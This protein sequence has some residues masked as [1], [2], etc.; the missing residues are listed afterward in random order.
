[1]IKAFS[2]GRDIYATIA[3]IAFGVPYEDCL[4]F[5]PETHEYQKEGKERRSSA[6]TIVLG[7]SYGR[8]VNTIA[9]QLF[10]TDD[11]LSDD[12]KVKKAQ[13][14]YDSVMNAFPNL[15]QLMISA[16]R[17]ATEKGYVD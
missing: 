5:H 14:V 9:D 8:S 16:Q 4:E 2:E 15:R 11:S 12:E 6:K 10:G 13:K 17:T 1:M 7:V 3:S